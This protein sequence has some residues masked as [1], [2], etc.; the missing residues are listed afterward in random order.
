MSR[1]DEILGRIRAGIG[2]RYDMPSLDDIAPITYPDPLAAFKASSKVAGSEVVEL[3][4]G[5]T[6]RVLV[7]GG[8][9]SVADN[10]CT[11]LVANGKISEE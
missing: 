3:E 8:V 5:E 10:K 6:V 1:K 7:G 4:S 11:V 9:A 2:T